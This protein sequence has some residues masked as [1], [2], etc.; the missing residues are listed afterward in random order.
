MRAHLVRGAP[1]DP[2]VVRTMPIGAL[3]KALTD[4][5]GNAVGTL[6]HLRTKLGFSHPPR[7][8]EDRNNCIARFERSLI[9]LQV[10]QGIDDH[11]AMQGKP[12]ARGSER[13]NEG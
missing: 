12:H 13:E 10:F 3:P 5:G 4:M 9:N 2:L 11:A 1:G 7:S 8:L 6:R